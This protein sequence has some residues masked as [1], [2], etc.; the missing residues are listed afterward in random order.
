MS[1]QAKKSLQFSRQK[2]KLKNETFEGILAHCAADAMQKSKTTLFLPKK[3][4]WKS[5]WKR[6]KCMCDQ[7]WLYLLIILQ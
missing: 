1:S 2:P 3:K 5:G 6:D 7:P 4:E